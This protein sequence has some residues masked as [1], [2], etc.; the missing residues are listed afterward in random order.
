MQAQ[1]ESLTASLKL[2]PIN[3]L[4]G[5]ANAFEDDMRPFSTLGKECGGPS[6]R[7]ESREERVLPFWR[8]Q[9]TEVGRFWD[10]AGGIAQLCIA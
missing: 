2:Q 9:G 5:H 8:T 10:N 7:L 3:G 4:R 1:S 6:Q